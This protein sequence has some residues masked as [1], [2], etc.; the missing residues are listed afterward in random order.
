MRQ[1]ELLSP[2]GDLSKLKHAFHYGAD[3]V[4]LSGKSFG[5]RTF[6][7]NFDHEDMVKGISLAHEL[8][9]KAYVTM[10]IMG[11]QKDFKDINDEIDFVANE[12]KADAVLVSDP[13]IFMRVKD[14]APN[15]ELHISTQASVT[16]SDACIFWAKQGA[17]R[18]VLARELSL[19]DI[20]DIR[21]KIPSD[22]ELETFVHGAMCM[23]YSGRCILS[24]FYTG[25]RSN[26]GA[27]AQPCRWGYSI[28]EEKRP[29]EKLPIESDEHGTYILSSRDMCMINHIPELLEA[30]ID[31]LKIEGRIKGE[32]YVSTVTK[33]YREAIDLYREDPQG[34]K[35]NPKWSS[36]LDKLVHRDYD[37]GFFFDY[38]LSDNKIGEN[39]T[40]NKPAYLVGVVESFDEERGLHRISQRNKLYAK[41]T[42]NVLTAKGYVEPL[43][44]I[45]LEDEKGNKID[46]TPHPQMT[47]YARFDKDVRLD[48]LT[49]LSRDG[50]KDY[51]ISP[52][53]GL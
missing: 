16:N 6:S 52:E 33:V 27:C 29:E 10:N 4:Y 32:Y 18:I 7:G 51:G 3:A 12:A 15:L 8:N 31:S 26:G 14:V 11:L 44:V 46:S 25:R 48:P 49:F 34:Y 23:S 5:L 24:N 20:R 9:K 43:K 17:R 41:D 2:A 47:Y 45:E 40:Y 13:G 42:V 28:Y 37:T 50:D 1:V 36:L 35:F 39:T 22:L 19:E 53:A 21:S 30:G 38:P